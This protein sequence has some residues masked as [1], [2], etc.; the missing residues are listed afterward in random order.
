MEL[1]FHRW[2]TP[3]PEQSHV[4]RTK[5]VLLHGM[6]G[7][8][9]IWRPLGAS[10]ENHFEILSPDQR[11]HGRSILAPDSAPRQPHGYTPLDYGKDILETLEKNQFHPTWILGHSMGVRSACAAAFL[12]PTQVKGLIL[13][14]LGFSGVAGGGLGE[15]LARFIQI[16][17]QGFPSRSEAKA[18]MDAH[19]P[20][21]SIAQYLM[22]VAQ[23]VRGG[24][25][26]ELYFPFDHSALIQTIEAARDSSARKWVEA[27]AGQ[28]MP[29]RVL[30]GA[31]SLVWS[32]EEFEFEKAHF[33]KHPNVEFFEVPEAG[34]GLPFEKRPWLAK[35]LQ[36]FCK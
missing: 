33:K 19:C 16:L 36:E 25:I 22:A 30:R 12:N 9:A 14:D 6:G 29:I 1:F 34:H 32:S 31:K 11:G 5:L 18:F 8:G 10:L 17:P 13:I 3:S 7:T 20:D 24:A 26:G 21:P 35:M 28:G 15:G 4:L 2:G 27:L 23:P